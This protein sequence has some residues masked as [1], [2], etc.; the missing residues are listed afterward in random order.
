MGPRKIES[1]GRGVV[2]SK[3]FEGGYVGRVWFVK[4]PTKHRAGEKDW[5][6]FLVKAAISKSRR[7]LNDWSKE[8]WRRR[9]VRRIRGQVS[10]SKGDIRFLMF[11]SRS[12]REFRDGLRSGEALLRGS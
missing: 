9:R 7:Q 10:R 4:L 12:I 2:V 8:R 6:V 3:C 1:L 5:T 11:V